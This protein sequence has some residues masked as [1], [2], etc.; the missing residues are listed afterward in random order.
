MDLMPRNQSKSISCD[1]T[2]YMQNSRSQIKCGTPSISSNTNT[3][4]YQKWKAHKEMFVSCKSAPHTWFRFNFLFP[5]RSIRRVFHKW[6]RK[7][8]RHSEEFAS[9]GKRPGLCEEV[10]GHPWS[11]EPRSTRSQSIIFTRVFF[12]HPFCFWR[13]I[14]EFAWKESVDQIS[15]RE[16][17]IHIYLLRTA[18]LWN[19][20]GW[21]F[22]SSLC[23]ELAASSVTKTMSKY[24]NPIRHQA[25]YCMV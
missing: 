16:F 11:C 25:S 18:Q 15:C 9:R 7:W 6:S 2:R 5:S 22:D 8:T 24:W 17:N 14:F 23:W 21:W 19:R 12:E 4:V 1:T 13:N 10:S 20:R 3:N